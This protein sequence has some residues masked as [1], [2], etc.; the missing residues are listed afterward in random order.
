MFPPKC[1][2]T[3]KRCRVDPDPDPVDEIKLASIRAADR[4]MLERLVAAER[5]QNLQERLAR[6]RQPQPQPQKPPRKQ[7]RP[8]ARSY[9]PRRK[10]KERVAAADAVWEAAEA[11]KIDARIAGILRDMEASF[12]RDT[13][14]MTTRP[15]VK[16]LL[17][18][19]HPDRI[20]YYIASIPYATGILDALIRPPMLAALGKYSVT[21]TA[22]LH[23]M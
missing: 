12:S 3:R 18:K 13:T 7:P 5:E 10:T 20:Q 1:D 22:A 15:I 21:L 19:W 23:S 4:R 2:R 9:R 17:L 16:K 6:Q 11:A 14:A 8:P